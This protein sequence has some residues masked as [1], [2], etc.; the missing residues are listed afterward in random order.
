MAWGSELPSLAV[1]ARSI[2]GANQGVYV[3]SAD[4]T[5][6]V[7]QAAERPV[8][9]A[10]VSKIATTLALLRKFG[11][12]HR[13][14]TLFAA[15]GPIRDGTLLGDLLVETEGD[16]Y[17]VDEN[18][19]LV[20]ERLL[21]IGVERVSGT[22]R[23]RGPLTFD[24]QADEDGI[25]LRRALAGGAP[26]A[27][28][29]AVQ[30]LLGE[31]TPGSAAGG[32]VSIAPP[33][34]RFENLV[35]D[36][37]IPVERPLVEHRSQPLLSLVKALNDYS[38]NIFKPLADAAGGAAAVEAL[39]RS[40]VPA[41]MQGEI[42][43]G[44]GAGTDP[45]NRMSPRAAV[46]LLRTLER[47]LRSSGHSLVDILPVSGIDDGTLR[48]RL[49]GPAEAGRV[50]GKTGTFGDYGASALIGAIETRDR[51]TV[52]FAILN[53]DVPVPA[54]RQRQDRFV[55]S[56]LARAHSTRWRYD[57]DARPAVNR[58]TAIVVERASR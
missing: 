53:H 19:L 15:T 7:S 20:A 23:T 26:P 8:H 45:S 35:A 37:A 29:T 33:A 52:Y 56:L 41:S 57:P 10:S 24:W 5:V 58:A 12:E 32:N 51:G 36:T 3:E 31:E 40:A 21:E 13:F 17:F 48:R 9:P 50:V 27:A 43:L 55:R 42:T 30:A 25:R 16:P 54:A 34:I 2:V 14:T 11:P 28:W 47:E 38:N 46:E 44:D 39:A 49:D 18:A 4:G 22:L 1:A 6:L